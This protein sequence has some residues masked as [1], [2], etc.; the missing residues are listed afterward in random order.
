MMDVYRII[1]KAI[2]ISKTALYFQN[3][4]SDQFIIPESEISAKRL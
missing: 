3:I 1:K 2:P 4:R